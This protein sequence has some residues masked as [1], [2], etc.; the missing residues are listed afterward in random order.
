MMFIGGIFTK[1]VL[2][3]ETQMFILETGSNII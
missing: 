3:N 2:L 1:P